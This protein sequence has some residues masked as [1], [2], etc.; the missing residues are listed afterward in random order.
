VES[1]LREGHVYPVPLAIR[2]APTK[3]MKELNY[4]KG[5]EYA[6]KTEEKTTALECLPE[7]LKNRRYYE[8]TDQG[9][10]KILSERKKE[11]EEVRRRL[12]AGR[13]PSIKR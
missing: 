10:E 13:D 6:H 2:N 4:G 12:R 3:L 1:D 7:K 11:W 9:K 8:P 5:Y